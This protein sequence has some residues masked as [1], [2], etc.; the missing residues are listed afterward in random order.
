MLFKKR[1]L[2][3]DS[4]AMK[5]IEIASRENAKEIIVMC[6]AMRGPREDCGT[7]QME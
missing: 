1:G 5:V 7:M 2:F 3:T 6:E 4:D